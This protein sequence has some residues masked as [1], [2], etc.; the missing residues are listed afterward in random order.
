MTTPAGWS[1]VALN[2]NSHSHFTDHLAAVA[3]L[4][5]I[6]LLFTEE[7]H[8]EDA[9]R[10]YPGLKAEL[11]DWMLL[12]P[13]YFAERYGVYFVSEMWNST[14]LNARF[15]AG[16]NRYRVVH[17]P[18]GFSD[19]GYWFEEC[20]DQDVNLVYG[21]NML[22]LIRERN[23]SKEMRS[24]VMSGNLRYD[25]YLRNKEFYDQLVEEEILSQFPQKQTTIIYA[26][27]WSDREQSTSF[28]DAADTICAG[29]PEHY[30]LI[31][32]L[33]P[34]LELNTGIALVYGLMAKHQHRKNIVFLQHFTPIYPLL[35][36]CDLYVGDRS[37]VGYDF[38]A[39]NRPMY[40]L[41]ARRRDSATDRGV[42][43]FRC[44][45]EVFSH[46]YGQLYQ[47]IEETLPSDKE[48]FSEIRK[49]VY[50]YSFVH[51]P[52]DVVR[53]EILA[54]TS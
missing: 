21:Q 16:D 9:S 1:G 3:V 12:K 24:Y 41:N 33:H 32:K 53:D 18:H 40:F 37:A 36:V 52:W 2:P 31:V 19:K 17:C 30:N 8:F 44:G 20:L 26:P 22:D 23:A 46:E 6:P 47:I 28:F 11:H 15:K 38:L 14:Q 25:Y 50:D 54:A 39:F 42:Y 29:L 34:N 49:Q 27:T 48:R 7:D 45:V 43:I 5:D 35:S 4:M 51:R 13:Q 10:C